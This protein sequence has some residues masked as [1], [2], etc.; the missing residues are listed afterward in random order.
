MAAG[1][2]ELAIV[3]SAWNHYVSLSPSTPDLTLAAD[4]SSAFGISGI[5]DFKTAEAGAEILATAHPNSFSDYI[6][7]AQDAYEAK[8]KSDGRLAEAH[9]IAV[10]PKADRTQIISYLAEFGGPSGPTGTTGATGSTATTG[11]TT[12]TGSTGKTGSSGAKKSSTGK[13]GTSGKTGTSG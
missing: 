8:Q 9:A 13:S 11:S 6:A 2:K 1:A 12:S 4:V 3:R 10:A 5:Q 7:L